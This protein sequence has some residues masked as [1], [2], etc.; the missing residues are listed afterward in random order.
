MEMKDIEGFEGQYAITTTG[1]VY[2]Y[3]TKRFLT[4]RENNRGY[5][6]VSLTVD[7]KTVNKF[8]HRLVAEA[9]IPNP[10]NKPTVDHID[11]NPHNNNMENLRWATHGEQEQNKDPEVAYQHILDMAA[12]RSKKV[13]MID[14]FTKEILQVFN[15]TREAGRFLGDEGKSSA[16]AKA[17]KGKLNTSSGYIWRYL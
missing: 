5:D 17:A 16:I 7:R 9:F 8:I 11:R 1:E 12:K 2:S 13:A 14:P 4:I 15:S 3:K 6:R 10:E